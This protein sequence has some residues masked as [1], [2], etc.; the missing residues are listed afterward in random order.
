[1]SD[2]ISVS[3]R[4]SPSPV[5]VASSGSLAATVL[6][7]S[8]SPLYSLREIWYRWITPLASSWG[9][10]DHRTVT[11]LVLIT[12]TIRG[13]T[14]PGAVSVNRMLMM[15][16]VLCMSLCVCVCVCVRSSEVAY[17]TPVCMLEGLL[18]ALACHLC[19]Q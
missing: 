10:G 9:T 5:N 1:M 8:C 2:R 13:G 3:G 16:N 14:A 12:S 18:E 17:Y 19:K 6:L 4:G 7:S 11:V 15:N